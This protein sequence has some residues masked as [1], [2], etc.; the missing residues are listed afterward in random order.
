MSIFHTLTRGELGRRVD[1]QRPENS[2]FLLKGTGS[3]PH[4]GGV[5]LKPANPPMRCS[6]AGCE[7]CRDARPTVLEKLEVSPTTLATCE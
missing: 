5:R 2:L 3:V 7:G 6:N 4:Q 1:R